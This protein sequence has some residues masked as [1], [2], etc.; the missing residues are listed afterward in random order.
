MASEKY[1]EDICLEQT[2]IKPLKEKK[3]LLYDFNPPVVDYPKEKTIHQLFEE[4]VERTPDNI[5]V[6]WTAATSNAQEQEEPALFSIREVAKGTVPF[7]ITYKELNKKA[8]HLTRQLK[9]RGIGADTIVAIMMEPSAEMIIGL[10]AILKAGGAY[11]PI[12]PGYPSNRI[13]YMLA[14][15]EAKVLVTTNTLTEKVEKVR[16]PSTN[17]ASSARF[18]SQETL[19]NGEFPGRLQGEIIFL[20]AGDRDSEEHCAPCTVHPANPA[21]FPNLAYIIY[22]SG[23]TGKPKGVMIEHRNVVSLMLGAQ[24]LFDFNSTDIWTMFHSFC[25]DFSVWEMYGALLY[26]GRLIVI[27]RMIAKDLQLFLIL[28]KKYCVTIL[29]QTP[30]SFYNL[31]NEE[32][33]RKDRQLKLKYVIFGGEALNPVK[34]K[35]WKTRYPG[36]RLINMYGITE[37]TVHVTYKEIGDKEIDFNISNIGKSIPSATTYV[38]EDN[39]NLLSIGMPGQLL[40]GGNGVG[41][42]YLNRQELTQAKYVENPFKN[43][44]KVYKS[45][46]LVRLLDYHDGE[47][48]Y[49]GRIDHQVQ[50]RGYRIELGEIENQLLKHGKV[51]AAVVLAREDETRG[52][53]LCAY[54]VP[55][56][57]LQVSGLRGYLSNH[58]PHYMIPSYFVPVEKIPLTSNGKPDR[59]ALASYKIKLEDN[60]AAPRDGLENELVEI[61]AEVLGIEKGAISIDCNF[62]HLGGH[63]LNAVTLAA[64]IYQVLKVKLPLNEIFEMQTIKNL[65]KCVKNKSKNDFPLITSKEKRYYYPLPIPHRKIFMD[66]MK[67]KTLK[68]SV[69][70]VYVIRG[71]LDKKRFNRAINEIVLRHEMLRTSFHL[72]EDDVVQ[73]INDVREFKVNFLKSSE[74]GA[75]KRIK[76]FRKPFDLSEAPLFRVEL[77]QSGKEKY[78]VLINIHHIITDAISLQIMIKEIAA[79][80]EGRTLVPLSIQFK[81]YAVW[82]NSPTIKET[83][84]HQERYWWEKMNNFKYTYL[85]PDHS[86]PIDKRKC[87]SEIVMI[88]ESCCQEMAAICNQYKV[89]RFAFLMAIFQ[90]VLAGEIQ[91]EDLTMGIR[92]S[93]RPGY[94]IRNALG[95]FLNKLL[96]RSIIDYKDTFCNHLQK[97]NKTLMEA[98]DNA[99]IPY[100]NLEIKLLGDKKMKVKRL[101]TIKINYFPPEESSEEIFRPSVKIKP[102]NIRKTTSRYDI[103]LTIREFPGTLELNLVY[104]SIRYFEQRI[105]R[106]MKGVERII[107]QVVENAAVG[108]GELYKI[109]S[110]IGTGI[111]AQEVTGRC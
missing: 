25:F 111:P 82:Y 5:A 100:E 79:L 48:E 51:K 104:N 99:L 46:D 23:T 62:F 10:L 96:I 105:K 55:G 106:M 91:Q 88:N 29:N 110:T 83:I 33:K 40:V 63:S 86:T 49:L 13:N 108:V 92:A 90:I 73:R 89:T 24:L 98:M 22:T 50:L 102:Y 80:Y 74:Q 78:F 28:M 43:G 76:Q 1:Y 7:M 69:L 95:Y 30:L 87:K 57:N 26:G 45:G 36:T 64:K 8:N 11:L 103:A 84:A 41:R 77:L 44:G 107:T 54:I 61:W 81:D 39:L 34:L 47:M 6:I 56:H 19:P 85:P 18:T 27:R 101:F 37:T 3:Q 32:M 38:A 72:V 4:Q 17:V 12:D 14:D 21:R 71:K 31:A 42:G 20:D 53:Y 67:A 2:D 15:S 35:E 52:K 60:Y 9:A 66:E 65:A 16:S 94:E 70:A 68:Y 109:K 58:L 59:K 97:V 75:K 93:I